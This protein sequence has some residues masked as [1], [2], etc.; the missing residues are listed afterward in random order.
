[1]ANLTSKV[2][3]LALV[4]GP[5]SIFSPM[6]F[7][8]AIATMTWRRRNASLAGTKLSEELAEVRERSRAMA[9]DIDQRLKRH[10][11]ENMQKLESQHAHLE[12]LRLV[13]AQAEE[14]LGRVAQRN[15]DLRSTASELAGERE[16]MLRR[17]RLL[18]FNMS[19]LDHI[20][21][22]TTF[23][24]QDD[25][26]LAILTKLDEKDDASR[27]DEELKR[28]LRAIE[29][30]GQQSQT[31]ALLEMSNETEAQQ[32]LSS[33]AESFQLM[34]AEAN[35]TAMELDSDFMDQI[36]AG[37]AREAALLKRQAWLNSSISAQEKEATQLEHIVD[38]LTKEKQTLQ[39][40][41]EALRG[42]VRRLAAR[43]VARDEHASPSSR[44][45]H[46]HTNRSHA[47]TPEEDLFKAPAKK[48][49]TVTH[50]KNASSSRRNQSETKAV[51]PTPSTL[52]ERVYEAEALSETGSPQST[53]ELVREQLAKL[54]ASSQAGNESSP[55]A[56]G[57]QDAF[58]QGFRALNST[59]A[60][61]K[62]ISSK[63]VARI[64]N[65]IHRAKH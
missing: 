33:L 34:E 39:Q 44:S 18:K 61:M 43:A 11:M 51:T 14:K 38:K 6:R 26:A 31:L 3:L 41:S 36:A 23:S 30:I 9:K 5:A 29:M 56:S 58:V 20:L 65:A 64:R 15:S 28:S 37:V 19:D 40:R 63:I 47:V 42:Y 45:D 54:N 50:A 22:R 53:E 32:L 46:V 55:L 59:E 7:A 57:V 16:A 10:Q 62:A 25:P 17:L 27:K 2:M 48:D 8:S 12:A 4:L 21:R 52:I 49:T 24:V 1:M 35:K 13:N 60:R